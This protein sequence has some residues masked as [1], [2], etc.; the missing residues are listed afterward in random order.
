MTG[1]LLR[2]ETPGYYLVVEEQQGG[3][4]AGLGLT[5]VNPVS[6]VR[7]RTDIGATLSFAE[8]KRLR[9]RLR[10]SRLSEYR[11]YEALGGEP[12]ATLDERNSKRR[13][14]VYLREGRVEL[15]WRQAK[16]L[17]QFL[18]GL[19]LTPVR[20]APLILREDVQAAAKV[21]R[22]SRVR[23][24]VPHLQGVHG[25]AGVVEQATQDTHIYD[26][27]V[28]MDE[29][30]RVLSFRTKELQVL[31]PDPR[32][33]AE[34]AKAEET[35]DEGPRYDREAD[36]KSR[37]PVTYKT[38]KPARRKP[39]APKKGKE[40][41][42]KMAAKTKKP[43]DR[44]V[45]SGGKVLGGVKLKNGTPIIERRSGKAA[46]FKGFTPDGRAKVLKDGDKKATQI[47]RATLAAA[48]TP[49]V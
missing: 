33:E 43:D 32:E 18:D 42:T 3:D 35:I 40:V 15:D 10:I 20:E 37:T 11:T 17:V 22:G 27:D 2:L 38:R 6:S 47:S 41:K 28:R 14:L 13:L 49:E 31:V 44:S 16:Q 48:Y 25:R 29:T 9:D 39:V 12:V 45:R 34:V 23:V 19:S 46:T 24:N 7:C 5:L 4:L 21:A 1:P 30:G 36:P 8:A 26:W